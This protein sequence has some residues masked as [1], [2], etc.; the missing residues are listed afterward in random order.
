M[1]LNPRNA[2]GLSIFIENLDDVTC[3]VDKCQAVQ[4][5]DADAV[6]RAYNSQESIASIESMHCGNL[7]WE[8]VLRIM[9]KHGSKN[10]PF[11]RKDWW[12]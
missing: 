5:L 12:L 8:L 3:A 6:I 2:A 9:R 11:G 10:H 4:Q 1:N 7:E